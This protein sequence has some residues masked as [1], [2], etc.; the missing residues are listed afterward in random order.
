[1]EPSKLYK[2]VLFL[3]KNNKRQKKLLLNDKC[4]NNFQIILYN[5]INN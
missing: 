3:W 5:T 1:M 4:S 2:K